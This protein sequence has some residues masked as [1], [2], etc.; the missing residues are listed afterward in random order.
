MTA[1]ATTELLD[2]SA[3]TP[4]EVLTAGGIDVSALPSEVSTRLNDLTLDEVI[5]LLEIKRRLSG[6]F[7][8]DTLM[9][10]GAVGF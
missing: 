2:V 7:P 6:D 1:V 9:I 4:L 5:T 10:E 3:K 8:E